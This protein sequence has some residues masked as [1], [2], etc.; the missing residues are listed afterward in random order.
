M[1]A[2][3]PM[4]QSPALT[5]RRA[6]RLVALMASVLPLFTINTPSQT[7]QTRRSQAQRSARIPVIMISIDGL[8]PDY[9]IEADKHGLKIPSLRRLM[10]EGAFASGVIGVAPTVTYPS[11]TTLV[12]GVT[13]SRHGIPTNMPLDPFDKNARGWYWYAEDI[14]AQTLWD[15]A[16]QAGLVTANIDWPVT[17]G[18]G[19]RYNIAQFWRASTP[20]DRKLLGALSTRGLLS[21][22]EKDCGPYPAGYNYDLKSDARRA[23]FVAW[24]IEKK[25]PHFLTG[26]FSALDEEQHDTGPYTPVTFETLEGLDALIGEIRAAAERAY[27]HRFILCVVSDHGH[28]LAEKE[29]HLNAMLS[30][31]G[32]IE[33]DELKRVKSWRA[34][35]WNSGGSAGIMLKDA[36]DESARQQVRELLNRLAADP[37]SGIERIIEDR[38]AGALG[39]FPGAAFVVGLKPGFRTG[40]GL[41]GAIVRAGKAGG[42]HGYLPG[43]RD[44]EASFFISGPGIAAGLELGQI[45]MRDIAPTLARLINVALPA[46]EGRNLLQK[47]LT[48]NNRPGANSREPR[49]PPKS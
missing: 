6:I 46:A 9:V 4:P 43:H 37:E 22:A 10:K 8:K 11:H 45:D 48:A 42:A 5:L 39:G 27:R 40:L 35:A 41:T 26:Y 28:I 1:K 31:A 29:L 2:I 3:H 25:R 12:T 13:P 7:V 44:M 17:V 38:E 30:E 21:E 34:Y 20:D 32:L 33:T 36:N 16:S 49:A 14:R 15:A 47:K 18:A 23:R 19:I 24:M